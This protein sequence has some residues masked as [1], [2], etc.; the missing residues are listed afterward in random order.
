MFVRL[1]RTNASATKYSNDCAVHSA[2]YIEPR[3]ASRRGREQNFPL[4]NAAG[5]CR[6]AG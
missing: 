1:K 2:V 5:L 6:A 3:E 4:T